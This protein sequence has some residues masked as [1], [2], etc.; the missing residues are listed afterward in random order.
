MAF[1]FPVTDR[2]VSHT[3]ALFGGA[4]LTPNILSDQALAAFAASV[5]RFRA[6]TSAA[7][8]DTLLQNHMLM[9]PIQAKLDELANRKAGDRNPFVVGTTAYQKFVGA[10]DA[11]T[12]VNLARRKG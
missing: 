12:N 2:G 7:G 5:A 6:Q 10:L 11:C 4:W 1:I 3:A 9:V 8:V